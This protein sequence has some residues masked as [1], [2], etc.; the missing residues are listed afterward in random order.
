MTSC[1]DAEVVAVACVEAPIHIMV[2]KLEVA[3]AARGVSKLGSES[4]ACMHMLAR[5]I[6]IYHDRVRVLPATR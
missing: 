5:S 6:M 1:G 2:A 3:H 4:H